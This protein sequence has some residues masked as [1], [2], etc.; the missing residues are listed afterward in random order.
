[1]ISRPSTPRPI[2]RLPS[3]P[4]LPAGMARVLAALRPWRH[5]LSKG[6]AESLAL[7]WSDLWETRGERPLDD[8]VRERLARPETA[9]HLIGPFQA[10]DRVGDPSAGPASSP[11]TP[12]W[13][14]PR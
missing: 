8:Q 3:A 1:M 13:S 14:P 5:Q 9:R 6:S 2:R 11:V 10:N 4:R 7:E 12:L